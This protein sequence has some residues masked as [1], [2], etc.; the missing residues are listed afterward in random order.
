MTYCGP[1]AAGDGHNFP[2]LI[3]EG[4]PGVAAVIN[5]IVVGFEQAI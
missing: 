2:G 1:V 5:D 3:D 4:V